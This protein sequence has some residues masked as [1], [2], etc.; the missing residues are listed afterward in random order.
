MAKYKL[1]K[2]LQSTKITFFA[3]YKTF[4]L[5]AGYSKFFF[6]L[7]LFT[8]IFAGLLPV[9]FGY[10]LKLFLDGLANLNANPEII[11]ISFTSWITIPDLILYSLVGFF[12]TYTLMQLNELIS[13]FAIRRRY[14]EISK[15]AELNFAKSISNIDLVMTSDS[16][17]MDKVQIAREKNSYI[18]NFYISIFV[19]SFAQL[20]SII[21]IA[22]ILIN[23]S[24]ITFLILLLGTLPETI[25][26]L[27]LGKGG[28]TIYQAGATNRRSFEKLKTYLFNNKYFYERKIY[29]SN[30]YLL[31]KAK[32]QYDEYYSKES[33]LSTK[34]LVVRLLAKI[35]NI[36]AYIT[37]LINAV[38]MFISG[39]I[40]IG[41]I[42]YLI[43][44]TQLFTEKLNFLII[45]I[46]ELYK[47]SLTIDAY[48]SI[49]EYKPK[50]VTGNQSIDTEQIKIEFKNVWFKYPNAK[51]YIFKDF[52][53]IIK[54]QEKLGIVGENGAGKSTLM[55]LLCRL[56]EVEKGTILLNDVDIKDIN[57]EHYYQKIG[58][59]T[60]NFNQYY[61]SVNENIAIS[62][63]TKKI[64]K[65]KVA[66]VS[67][68][69]SAS[70]FING[71]KYKYHQLLSKEF[72]KGI[73]PS[74]GQWQKIAIARAMYRNPEILIFDE[75]TSAI[76]PS[77]EY[78]IIQ[79]LYKYTKDKT[80]III[81][82]RFA[83]VKN[84]NRIIVLE[85]GTI[86][87]DGSHNSL[88]KLGG[89]Y[90]S[91]YKIQKDSLIKKSP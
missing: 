30:P 68:F 62:D 25:L 5:A 12:I 38:K 48:I 16:K 10:F 76:D 37:V 32:E 61:F 66:K 47:E 78:E 82:H 59:L 69:A 18:I 49:L 79:N 86:I 34:R 8:R 55:L 53:L 1:K 31:N 75:P 45:N 23:Y 74:V 52:N 42:T 26:L 58:L 44:L 29:N 7:Y 33:H 17:F 39:V 57:L 15:N 72:P 60:Q 3:I 21:S 35:L 51:S 90:A 4:L 67:E 81:S 14:L 9:L 2:L 71:Y 63:P 50:I 36:S 41:S 54:P 89:K 19:E 83:N 40:N 64:D 43:Q 27:S 91:A 87:E 28:F 84:A 70:D 22:I 11:T 88:M 77:S 73:D 6:W 56:Y 80:L 24:A 13:E 46:S 85:N 65:N 20:V